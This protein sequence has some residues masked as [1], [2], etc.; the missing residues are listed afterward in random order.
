MCLLGKDCGKSE[1]VGRGV[2]SMGEP[3][4]EAGGEIANFRVGC[5]LIQSAHI[6]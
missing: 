6:G 1:I 4:R 5:A 2:E 3:A